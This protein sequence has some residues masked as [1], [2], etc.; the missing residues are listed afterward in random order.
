MPGAIYDSTFFFFK[1]K[2]C[3]R[4]ALCMSVVISYA[5]GKQKLFCFGSNCISVMT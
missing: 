4:E 2:A 3:S 5:G 1:Q